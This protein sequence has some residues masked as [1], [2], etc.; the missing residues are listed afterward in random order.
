[1][2]AVIGDTLYTLCLKS[3]CSCTCICIS[4]CEFAQHLGELPQP[5]FV[6]KPI[7]TRRKK[8]KIK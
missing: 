7:K 5:M 3:T 1:M 8:E 2:N 6:K 4:E